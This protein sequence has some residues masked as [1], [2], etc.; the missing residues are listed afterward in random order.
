MDDDHHLYLLKLTSQIVAA[1]VA[2]VPTSVDHLPFLIN[3]VYQ[4]LR[5]RRIEP[6]ALEARLPAVAIN[7]SV[8]PNYLI[9]LE[10]GRRLKLLKRH[11]QASYGLTPEQYRKRWGLPSD[12]PMVA[13]HY[14]SQR[15][16]LA[17]MS[18]LGRK[19]AAVNAPPTKRK[20]SSSQASIS[21]GQ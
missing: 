19:Q 7:R 5:S 15:S 13:P 10:D 18:G 1:H 6:A 12:Y 11:L 3:N 9:C 20:R 21:P 14:A 8:F 16:S 17:K 4:A 2:H